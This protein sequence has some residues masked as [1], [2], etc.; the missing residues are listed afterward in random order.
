MGRID[1]NLPD[2]LENKLRM[3]IGRR[4]G[5]KRGNFTEAIIEAID[6]WLEKDEEK[7]AKKK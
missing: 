7:S 1:I 2:G 5:A 6:L 4:M 3:E